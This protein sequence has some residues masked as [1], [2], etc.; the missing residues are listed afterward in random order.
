ML[1]LI[2]AVED[3]VQESTN[4]DRKVRYVPGPVAQG[5]SQY[6]KRAAEELSFTQEDIEVGHLCIN[7][8]KVTVTQGRSWP[9]NTWIQLDSDASDGP[10]NEAAATCPEI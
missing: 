7:I 1:A 8:N 5:N 4:G 6:W 10:C 9:R 3:S 2:K